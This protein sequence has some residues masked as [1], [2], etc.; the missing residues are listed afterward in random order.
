[1]RLASVASV[2]DSTP[3]TTITLPTRILLLATGVK[4][5]VHHH[6]RDPEG[7]RFWDAL[8]RLRT[9]ETVTRSLKVG[10]SPQA[11]PT[12]SRVLAMS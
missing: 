12:E 4:N 5:D 3:G 10:G 1:V 8:S 9:S 6:S 11:S 7:G 2:G